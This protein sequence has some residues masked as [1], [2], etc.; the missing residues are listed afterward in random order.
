MLLYI[1]GFTAYA[2]LY[3]TYHFHYIL[4]I[5]MTLCIRGRF[6]NKRKYIKHKQFYSYQDRAL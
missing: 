1:L 6:I 5:K 3:I 2:Y 4:S